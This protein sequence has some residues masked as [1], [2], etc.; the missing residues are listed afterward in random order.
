MV[1]TGGLGPSG[2]VLGFLLHTEKRGE[3]GRASEG[4]GPQEGLQGGAMGVMRGSLRGPLCAVK[5]QASREQLVVQALRNPNPRSEST[6]A[7]VVGT[8]R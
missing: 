7:L 2:R 6:S 4:L 5:G 3:P 1:P 8:G